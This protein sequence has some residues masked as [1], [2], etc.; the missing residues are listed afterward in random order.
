MSTT[1]T[2]TTTTTTTTIADN[3]EFFRNGIEG[4]GTYLCDG[5]SGK[6]MTVKQVVERITRSYTPMRPNKINVIGTSNNIEVW[7]EQNSYN[8]NF[9]SNEV[10]ENCVFAAQNGSFSPANIQLSKTVMIVDYK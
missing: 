4:D 10:F 8:T 9:P 2:T 1:P 6:G 7:S 3:I 5:F